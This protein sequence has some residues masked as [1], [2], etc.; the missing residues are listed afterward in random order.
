MPQ[1][2]LKALPLVTF[3][4]AALGA[5]FSSMNAPGFLHPVVQFWLRNDSSR[6]IIMSYDGTTDHEIVFQGDSFLIYAGQ[7]FSL[8]NN[9]CVVLP[10]FMQIYGRV[11]APATGNVYISAY[12]I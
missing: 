7:M 4:S 3:D 10:Q 6:D 9:R 12:Y 2:T 8:P 11:T 1:N 5:A